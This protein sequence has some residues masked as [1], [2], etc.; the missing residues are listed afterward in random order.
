MARVEMEGRYAR[1]KAELAKAYGCSAADSP[2]IDRL[3]RELL[4]IDRNARNPDAD[5]RAL[6]SRAQQLASDRWPA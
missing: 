3:A 4:E 5:E 2:H 6:A 1:L